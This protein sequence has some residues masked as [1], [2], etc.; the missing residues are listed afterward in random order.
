SQATRMNGVQTIMV[1][2]IRGYRF[3]ISPVLSV[4][5]GP[6]GLGCRFTPTCS[7][8]ALDAVVAHGARQVGLLALRRLCRC[9]PWGG[10]GFDPVPPAPESKSSRD[11]TNEFQRRAGESAF[12][13]TAAPG[14]N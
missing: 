6:L 7:Q 3:V 10:S 5:A 12:S 14:R 11:Q 8:Y 9:H 4:F 2:L 1:G 13:A